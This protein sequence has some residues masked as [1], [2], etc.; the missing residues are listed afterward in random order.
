MRS[1]YLGS[2]NSWVSIENCETGIS[3]KK[4]SSSPSI[5]CTQFPLTLAWPTSAHK[6]QRLSLEQGVINFGFRK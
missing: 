6:V 3:I 2:Q 1:S 4:G 5:K